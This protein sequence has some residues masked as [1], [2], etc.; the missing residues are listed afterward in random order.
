MTVSF[1]IEAKIQM[2]T[3]KIRVEKVSLEELKKILPEAVSNGN[4]NSKNSEQKKKEN[5]QRVAKASKPKSK[6]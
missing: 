1:Y 6:A 5:K 3:T 4:D 2:R